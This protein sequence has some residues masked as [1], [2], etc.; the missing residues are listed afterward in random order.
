MHRLTYP[1]LPLSLFHLN[2]QLSNSRFD[3][4]YFLLQVINRSHG[5]DLSLAVT[6]LTGEYVLGDSHLNLSISSTND[7]YHLAVSI[8]HLYIIF[9][10]SVN[11]FFYI[12]TNEYLRKCTLYKQHKIWSSYSTTNNSVEV[13]CIYKEPGRRWT[14]S[15]STCLQH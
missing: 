6:H 4:I 10:F 14:P 12:N 1:S 11:N 13:V 5:T 7:I 8:K 15:V 9:S 3:L 2:A